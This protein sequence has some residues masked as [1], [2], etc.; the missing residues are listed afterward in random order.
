MS[1]PPFPQ[2]PRG[3]TPPHLDLHRELM[4]SDK[5]QKIRVKLPGSDGEMMIKKD[6]NNDG[7]AI[8]N[9]KNIDIDRNL[10]KN[11]YF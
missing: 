4:Y 5:Q 10:L 2:M 9:H 3:H 1:A 11:I 7:R 6:R 8:Y